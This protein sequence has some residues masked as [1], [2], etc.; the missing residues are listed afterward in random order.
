MISDVID[1]SYHIEIPQHFGKYA[2]V[3]KIGSGAFSTVILV[4]NPKTNELFACKV[5]SRELLIKEK[6]FDRFEQELR[7]LETLDHPNIVRIHDIIYQE[8]LIIVVMEY[9]SRGELFS[10]LLQNGVLADYQIK[11][12][13]VQLVDA[14]CYLH[15][16]NI[17]HRDIKPEN[18]L[19]DSDL[20]VKLA[21]FGLCHA[22]SE[23]QM[24]S[25]PCGSPFY[26]PPEIISNIP[27]DGKKGDMWSL[28]VVIF[29]M[30]TG[31]LPWTETNQALLLQQ[32]MNANFV[33]PITVS[34]TIRHLIQNLMN[35]N[36]SLRPSAE[37]VRTLPWL[38]DNFDFPFGKPKNSTRTVKDQPFPQ[39]S[40]FGYNSAASATVNKKSLIVRPTFPTG[41]A[42]SIC[43]VELSPI[44]DLVR[45]VPIGSRHSRLAKDDSMTNAKVAMY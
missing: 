14:L 19:L 8:K 34:P 39:R 45:K 13:L 1:D 25:T 43:T 31:S 21:D 36:P 42:K 23:K 35:P 5:V 9:C 15:G 44:I 2:Y 16:R 12:M 7:M 10:Y 33:V 26:A 6:I 37:E 38:I 41:K 17:A 32:I 28:G 3:K 18:I 11:H 30:A 20:N 22:T 29:A 27:Y 4:E 40:S 24:L